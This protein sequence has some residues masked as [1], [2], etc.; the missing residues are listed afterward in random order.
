MKI[1]NVI[2]ITK[3]VF[4]E[5]LSYFTAKDIKAGTLVIVPMRKKNVPAIVISTEEIKSIKYGLKKAQFKLRPIK[6]IQSVS[7]LE[8]KFIEACKKIAKYFISPLG[9]V[10]K[11]FIPQAILTMPENKGRSFATGEGSSFPQSFHHKIIM[12]Q[13]PKEDRISYYKSIIREEFAKGHSIFLC[14]PTVVEINKFSNELQKGIEKYTVIMHGKISA[15][16]IREDW[17]KV[18]QEKHPLLI[19]ATK[20]FFSLPRKDIGTMIIDC[21]SSPFYRL[22]KRPY[23]DVRMAAEIFSENMKTRLIF[24]DLFIRSETFYKHES[25]ISYPPSRLLSEAKQIIIDITINRSFAVIS[26]ELKKMIKEIIEN[27]EKIILFINRRGHSPVTVCQD[28]LYPVLCEKCDTPLVLHKKNHKATGAWICHKCLTEKISPE[29][30]PYCKSWRL[31]ILGIGIQKVIEN[32]SEFFPKN[33]TFRMDSDIIKT[34]KQGNEIIKKFIATPGSILIGTEILFSYLDQPVER[35]GVVS[36]DSLFTLP[37]FRINEKIFSLL[38]KLRALAKKNFMI[39]TRLRQGSGGQARIFENVIKGN[40]SGFYKEEIENRKNFNYP[41]FKTLIKITRK[42]KNGAQTKKEI[43][44][45][46]KKLQEWNPVAYPAFI[47]KIKNIYVWHLLLKI[48]PEEWPEKQEKLH[49][50]L[51]LLTPQWKINIDPESLL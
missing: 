41:P 22:Q 47:P 34:E 23:I 14:L 13:A 48:N 4:Q 38:L 26:E 8:P 42:G 18:L 2:P 12:V 39:Q 7:F 11:D 16:K 45:L 43:D 37:D 21:E 51:S 17:N 27:N 46:A 20:S 28:C 5:N 1:V 3:G 35:V 32:L 6:S 44:D 50:I 49:Q 30:C 24:G 36:I 25:N 10:I 15:K 40:I 29:Q 19:I 33:K 9:A 31:E